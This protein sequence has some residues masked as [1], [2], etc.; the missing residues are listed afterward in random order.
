MCT[1][2]IMLLLLSLFL[3]QLIIF[4][5]EYKLRRRKVKSIRLLLKKEVEFNLLFWRGF[6]EFIH[7]INDI[8]NIESCSYFN[9]YTSGSGDEFLE[10]LTKDG[11]SFEKL[12][13]KVVLKH[14]EMLLLECD[15]FDDILYEN[16][17]NSYS[18]LIKL[19]DIRMKFIGVLREA[20][21]Y[22]KD[23]SRFC[24]DISGEISPICKS[25]DGCFTYY[26]SH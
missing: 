8:N 18:K 12:W 3:G 13:P 5:R 16:L 6:D 10:M 14:H 25:L 22:N 7:Y 2:I 21:F 19:K 11:S 24:D 1:Y 26:C 20:K 15:A 17:N 23:V 4:K 9:L